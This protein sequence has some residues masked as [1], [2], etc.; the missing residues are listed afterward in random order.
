MSDQ[1]RDAIA[2]QI[3]PFFLPEPKGLF[4]ALAEEATDKLLAAIESLVVPRC[5]YETVV[6]ELTEARRIERGKWRAETLDTG[7]GD[8]WWWVS[9]ED[10]Q[11]PEPMTPDEV[12]VMLDE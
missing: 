10:D 1:L 2:A 11:P 5:E 8:E 6:A 9:D 3:R 12:A 7:D 4:D